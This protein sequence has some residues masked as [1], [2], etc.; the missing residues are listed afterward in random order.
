MSSATRPLAL[1]ALRT[2]RMG[3]RHQRSCSGLAGWSLGV[4][5]VWPLCDGLSHGCA[6]DFR[7][8]RSFRCLGL[9][10]SRTMDFRGLAV[11][12]CRP[13]ARLTCCFDGHSDLIAR[14]YP[15]WL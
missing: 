4:P 3:L 6:R 5:V 7:V 1:W 8:A 10:R 14:R 13:S 15:E 11:A 12:V 9:D 2:S